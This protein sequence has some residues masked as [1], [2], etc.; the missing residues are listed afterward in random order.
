V[1]ARNWG[2]YKLGANTETTPVAAFRTLIEPPAWLVSVSAKYTLPSLS[3]AIPAGPTIP[4]DVSVVSK[5][6]AILYARIALFP[7]SAMKIVGRPAEK[8]YAMPPGLFKPE[9]IRVD[10]LPVDSS[11]SRSANVEVPASYKLLDR[12]SLVPA[13]SLAMLR[14]LLFESE[15]YKVVMAPP[16]AS[17][18]IFHSNKP[19]KAVKY[20][21]PP[22]S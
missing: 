19:L 14:T 18:L 3:A 1:T 8:P 10:R 15:E 12:Y 6:L 22:E 16:T 20:R 7:V 5:P 13:E 9:E 4:L 11:S 2:I 21:L 17:I